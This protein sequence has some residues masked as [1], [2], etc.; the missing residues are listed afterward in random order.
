MKI[1]MRGS[2]PVNLSPTMNIENLYLNIQLYSKEHFA[3][4]TP[5]FLLAAKSGSSTKRLCLP[6]SLVT[7]PI[8]R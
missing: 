2:F 1:Q 8:P 4:E 7:L 5:D 3:I 6:I